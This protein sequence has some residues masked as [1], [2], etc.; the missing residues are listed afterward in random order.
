MHAVFYYDWKYLIK[1]LFFS[2]GSSDDV[3]QTSDC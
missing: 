1:K 2:G 3:F